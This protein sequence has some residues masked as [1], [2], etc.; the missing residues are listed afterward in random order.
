[1]Q[2]NGNGKAYSGERNMTILAS[3]KKKKLCY[4]QGHIGKARKQKQNLQ[5][6]RTIIFVIF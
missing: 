1:M 3:A 5:R 2:G 6:R 4:M